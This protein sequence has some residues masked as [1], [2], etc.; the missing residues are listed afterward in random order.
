MLDIAPPPIL[1]GGMN[2]AVDRVHDE[3]RR[4]VGAARDHHAVQQL[5]EVL[6]HEIE[7]VAGLAHDRHGSGAQ[8][9]NRVR[10]HRLRA[11]MEERAKNARRGLTPLWL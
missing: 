11:E 9:P 2:H 3:S 5:D 6:R 10:H 8:R 4:D 7:R 1:V